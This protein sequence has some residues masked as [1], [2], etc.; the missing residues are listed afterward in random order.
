MLNNSRFININDKVLLELSGSYSP[1]SYK[2]EYSINSFTGKKT[3]YIAYS[4]SDSISN[5]DNGAEQLGELSNSWFYPDVNRY[6]S[7]SGITFTDEVEPLIPIYFNKLRIHLLSG[8]NFNDAEGFVLNAYLKNIKHDKVN[9]LSFSFLKSF[10][11]NTITINPEPLYINSKYYNRYIELDLL[12]PEKLLENNDYA[13]IVQELTDE[14]ID[15][16]TLLYFDFHSINSYDS[17]KSTVN[18]F[19]T[20]QRA[21]TPVDA[22]KNFSVKFEE[23]GDY[24]EYYA[25]YKGSIISNFIDKQSLVGKSW[26]LTH[27]IEVYEQLGLQMVKTDEIEKIQRSNFEKPLKFRP[28]IE[29]ASEAYSFTIKYTCIFTEINSNEQFYRGASLSSLSPKKYGKSLQALNV[30]G[31]LRYEVYKEIP[32]NLNLQLSL[33]EAGEAKTA[34]VN[35]YLDRITLSSSS[36]IKVMPFT[37]V[38]SFKFDGSVAQNL[39]YFIVFI[40]DDNEKLYIADIEENNTDTELYFKISESN[41]TKIR[42]FSNRTYYIVGINSNGES[43]V[44]AN[45]TFTV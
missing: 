1:H 32:K 41:A 2:Y 27:K 35:H 6:I 28:I 42:Q 8:Y 23:V 7:N 39:E 20:V 5:R 36:E 4:E 10:P 18:T 25:L 33:N 38:Y 12:S 24:F 45:G 29:Y 43:T 11:N 15:N 31:L 37:N 13:F 16:N 40:S 26:I 30:E 9:L 17:K 21:I 14:A 3:F 19:E 22:Y 44:L 34:I